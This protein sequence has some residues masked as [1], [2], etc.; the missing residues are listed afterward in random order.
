MTAEAEEVA[1]R[2]YTD[3][4]TSRISI[5]IAAPECNK[6]NRDGWAKNIWHH[7]ILWLPELGTRDLRINRRLPYPSSQQVAD[8]Y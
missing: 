1:G 3:L 4:R 2:P 8:V 6:P 5:S 7:R